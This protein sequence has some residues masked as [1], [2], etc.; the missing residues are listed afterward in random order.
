M[1]LGEDYLP[2][3]LSCSPMIRAFYSPVADLDEY[4]T[5]LREKSESRRAS[6]P[7]FAEYHKLLEQIRKVNR[8]NEL[9]LNIEERKKLAGIEKEISRLQEE[10]TPDQDEAPDGEENPKK[11][12]VLTES[13]M[14]LSDLVAL[15]ETLSGT[16]ETAAE[17]APIDQGV[18]RWQWLGD[19]F[20][21]E[22]DPAGNE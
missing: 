20:N 7:R 3:A 10:M 21:V 14:I 15:E 13:L 5:V 18:N 9:S 12:L 22:P 8:T 6:D 4:V 11:D 16:P 1:D 19:L 2:N 17:P